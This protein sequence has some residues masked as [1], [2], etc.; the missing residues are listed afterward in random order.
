MKKKYKIYNA[1]TKVISGC[2]SF[3][4]PVKAV[5]YRTNRNFYISYIA[6]SQKGPYKNWRPKVQSGDD[7]YKKDYKLILARARD[8]ARNNANISGAIDKI[9]KNVIR[10]GLRPQVQIRDKNNK[11]NDKL[12]QRIENV[13]KEWSRLKICDYDGHDTFYSLQKLVLR[14]LWIDGECFI[15]KMYDSSLIAYG[16]VPLRLQIIETEMLDQSVNGMLKNGNEAKKG[17]EFNKKGQVI[18]YHFYS[19]HPKVFYPNKT[20]RISASDIIHVFEKKRA[21]MT[22]GLSSLVPIIMDMYD[23]G[24]YQLYERI[25]AKVAAAFGVFIKT[26][27]PEVM[28]NPLGLKNSEIGKLPDYIEPGR[29]QTLPVGTEIQIASHKRPGDTYKPYVSQCLKSASA[30]IGI[31]YSSFSNDYTDSSYASERSAT[32]EERLRYQE[33]QNIISEKFNDPVWAWFMDS[34]YLSSLIVLPDYYNKR[35]LYPLFVN[36]LK[37][38]WSWVDP[39]KDSRAAE[40]EIKNK[41]NTRKNILSQK[42][43]DYDEILEQIDK[44]DKDFK[45][46]ENDK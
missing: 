17:I 39:L 7:E 46:Y 15:R 19:S 24:E 37:P 41:I 43:L 31:S 40:I 28:N 14:H 25:G 3:L 6:A 22:R 36:W 13:F 1:W 44:E 21:S 29:I 8:L 32:L 35:F 9:C 45:E 12:N 4:N 16:I 5:Q 11:L 42:G 33:L 38:G 18:A 23:L 34:L 20:V 10:E 27:L 26:N 2:I 30:G